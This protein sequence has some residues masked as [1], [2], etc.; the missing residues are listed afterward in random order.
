MCSLL[1]CCGIGSL[2]AHAVVAS[3]SG[4]GPPVTVG[5]AQATV[6]GPRSQQGGPRS[7]WGGPRSQWGAPVTVG[8][9]RSQW[10]PPVTVG[11][12]R[13]Q[14]GGPR[15]QWG[16]PGHSRGGPRSQ[17]GAPVTVGGTSRRSYMETHG[18]PW[19]L[20]TTP[21]SAARNNPSY[22][23]ACEISSAHIERYYTGQPLTAQLRQRGQTTVKHGRI[24]G[25]KLILSLVYLSYNK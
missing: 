15:P 10:G 13:S 4:W 5:G 11:G 3:C 20:P 23:T 12:P 19:F 1:Q 22:Y 9:P 14:Q 24:N 7:Q 16:A 18:L 25:G 2:P 17:W 6:G 8:G 21:L